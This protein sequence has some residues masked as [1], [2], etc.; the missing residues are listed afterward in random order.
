MKIGVISDTHLKLPTPALEDA[1][2]RYFREAE[3][4]LHAG[5]LVDV[6][7]LKAFGEKE[8]KAVSGNNDSGEVKARFPEREIIKTGAFKICLVHG[9]G[10]PFGVRKRLKKIIE[11]VDCIV[12]G[13]SHRPVN[14]REGGVLY[15][16][17]GAFRGGYSPSGRGPSVC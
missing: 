2:G 7:I 6:E 14:L 16:N 15:F 1:V 11:G 3:M 13:H 8:V 12:F 5:D 17:P 10:F 4:I 9:W